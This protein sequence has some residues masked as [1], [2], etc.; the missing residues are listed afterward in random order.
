MEN[1]KL[2][3]VSLNAY[4]ELYPDRFFGKLLELSDLEAAGNSLVFVAFSELESLAKNEGD[5]L[6]ILK[7][8]DDD[9]GAV[10]G[11]AESGEISEFADK[12]EAM[13]KETSSEE[14]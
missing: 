7:V 13:K 8:V 14:I 10:Y 5:Y 2:C 12:I 6:I 4:H 1:D 3:L 9:T 11:I